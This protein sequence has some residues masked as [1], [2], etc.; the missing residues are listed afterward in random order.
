MRNGEGADQNRLF[1]IFSVFIYWLCQL[2][3][4][5]VLFQERFIEWQKA[6]GIQREIKVKGQKMGTVM[7]FKYLGAIVRDEGSKPEVLSRI[8]QA[9]AAL[10]KLKPILRD[11]NISLGS[12]VKLMRSF[13]I[14]IFLHAC[15]SLTLTEELEKRTQAFEMRCY[16]RLLNISCYQWGG[17]QKDSN[18]HWRIRRTPDPRKE[19]EA[20][21]VWPCFKVFWSSKDNATGHSERKKKMRRRGGKTISKSGQEWILPAQLCSWKQDKMERECCEFIC[22]APTTLRQLSWAWKKFY[23]LGAWIRYTGPDLDTCIWG[24]YIDDKNAVLWSSK[25][26]YDLG[27]FITLLYI[28]GQ[29]SS[30]TWSSLY[31][32]GNF[33]R[34]ELWMFTSSEKYLFSYWTDRFV[35]VFQEYACSKG[36]LNMY[37]VIFHF[38]WVK[39]LCWKSSWIGL[40]KSCW[41]SSWIGLNPK[42]KK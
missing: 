21:N 39:K 22:G 32:H 1:W 28:L 2:K 4:I 33:G 38:H 16:R 15:E 41:K 40:A 23:N 26:V 20:K 24:Y 30:Y 27:N 6:N 37:E 12:K 13:A 25:M 8:A 29:K 42:L 36:L 3:L 7:S 35:L 14:S 18:S 19:M 9:T 34:C 17:S 11:N 10:T 31:C 5:Y